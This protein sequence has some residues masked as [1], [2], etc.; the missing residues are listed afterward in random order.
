MNAKRPLATASALLFLLLLLASLGARFWAAD[1]IIGAGGPTHIAADGQQVMLFAAG[2]LFHLSAAG[3]LLAVVPIGRTGLPDDPVDLRFMED[4]SLLVAGQR[5]AMIL[6]CGLTAWDCRPVAEDAARQIEHQLKVIPG[7][8]PGEWYLT[9]AHG[10]ALWRQ[11]PGSPPEAPLAPGTLAGPNGLALAADG[12]LWV[13]DTNHRRIIELVA[14][15]AG[16]LTIAREHPGANVFLNG[17]AWY[18][19]MLALGPDGRWWVIQGAEYSNSQ[20]ELVIYDPERGAE[21]RVDFPAGAYPTDLAA[22]GDTVLVTDMD[23]MEVYRVAADSLSIEPFGAAPFRAR[24]ADLRKQRALLERASMAA[25]IAVVAFGVLA[26]LA[27]MRATP[28]EKRWTRP[29]APFDWEAAPE[30]APHT[31]GIHW[32]KRNPATEQ[33]LKWAEKVSYFLLPLPAV[34]GLAVFFAFYAQVGPDAPADVESKLREVGMALL[35]ATALLALMIPLVRSSMRAFR[36]QLGTD[37]RRLHIRR[38]DGRE[39]AIDPAQIAYTDRMILYQELQLPLTGGRQRSLYQPGEVETWLAPLL[40]Q[41][42]K[43][44]AREAL[45][46][47][48]RHRDGSRFWILFLA[49]ALGTV[50]LAMLIGL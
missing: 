16:S 38:H 7:L 13:A 5:P 8:Q 35:L 9:D 3:D 24:L 27:A 39:I 14:D 37:G 40:R 2:N 15:E 46:H 4:G 30:S 20:S 47:Q 45:Q 32:L 36:A 12:A 29:Q 23:R 31:S 22:S 41:A 44:S 33:S 10:D 11:S 48:W 34:L 1:K 19:M 49:V 6:R 21:D 50:L 25:L 42:R 43:L 28:G 17:P 26:I 18:P